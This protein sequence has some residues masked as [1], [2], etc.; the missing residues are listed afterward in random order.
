MRKI[1]I[2]A[3]VIVIS[4]VSAACYFYFF[5]KHVERG[6]D[7]TVSKVIDGD[8]IELANGDIIRLIGIDAP[9]K[10]QLHYRD[11]IEQLKEIEGKAIRMEKDATNKDRYG[12]YLRYVFLDD[13]FVN[14]ELVQNGLVYAY[15]VSPDKKY[16]KEIL[17]AENVARSNGIGVW[18]RSEYS[19][20]VTLESF[21]YNAKGED[22][23]NLLD[24]FFVVENSC[25]KDLKTDGW[26]A[27]NTF[28]TYKI[29][30]S[31]FPEKTKLKIVSG[32]GNKTDGV[33]FISSD[34][35][36]WNNK[37]DVLYLRDADGRVI[38]EKSYKNE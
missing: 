29:P 21:H 35:P 22:N 10:T 11:A 33:A 26:T 20:C 15:I 27:R 17:E 36:I 16:E 7:A 13:H 37:G 12:R 9:E 28:N 31:G 3:A 24:E 25:G 1:T 23:K 30:E 14:L 6:I 19:D 5:G 8:T 32:K 34:R 4:L 38:L 18:D 2:L